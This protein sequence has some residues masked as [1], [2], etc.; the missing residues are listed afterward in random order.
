MKALNIKLLRNLC[1]LKGQGLAIAAVIAA[2]VA[3]YVMSFTALESLRLSQQSVYQ[4]QRFA[5]V[6]AN[7]QRAPEQLAERLREVPGVAT[8]ET[9]V[10]APLTMRMDDFDDPITG[11]AVS[12]PDGTQPQLNQLFLRAGQLPE[13]G[14]ADQILVSEAFAEAQELALGETL[15]IVIGGRF[16]RLQ[17]SGVALSPEYIY[18]IRPG[19]LFPDFSRYA[20]VWMNRSALAAAFGMEGAFNNVVASLSPGFSA[21]RVIEGLDREL[22]RWGGVGAYD[23][24]DQISHRYLEQELMGIES[25]ALFMPFIFIGVAA[26]L[27]NVVAARLIRTQREQIA[28]LKAFGYHST[29]VGAHYLLLVLTVVAIGSVV[30]VAL[31]TWLASGLAGIYQEYFRFP[32]LEFRL[33]PAVALSA[34]LIAGGATVIGT[35]SAVYRAF[36]LPPA[37][38]MRPEPPARFRRTLI[39]RLGIRWLSQPAR[40]ILRNLERQRL[41]SLLSMVGIGFAVAIMMLTGFQRGAINHMMDVQFS[42]AQRQDMTITFAEPTGQRALNELRALPGVLLVEGFRSAPVILRYGHREHQTALQG[43]PDDR[44][45]THVLNDQLQPVELPESGLL[46]T[47]HLA[48]M[49]RVQP[50]DILQVSVQEGR[51]PELNIPVAG[52]VTEFLGVGAYL[53]QNNLTTL[54]REGNTISGAHLMID[55]AHVS[56]LNRRLENMP[57]VAGISLRSNTINAFNEMMDETIIVFTLFSAV[58]AGAIAFAVVYNNARIALAE[59]GRELASLRVLGFTRGE[60][61]YILL[62]ELLL[63]TLLAMPLGFAMGAFLS[64]GLADAM[65]TDMFR[66][67]LVLTPQTYA[68][69]AIVVLVATLI[70]ALIVARRLLRLDIV[71][72]LKA[73]E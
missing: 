17:V 7:L 59:R 68:L 49:L 65:A 12:I 32:W 38:A 57:R 56:E 15:E 42:L 52:L 29:A 40:M 26:F 31:G 50:G 18:Q 73:A 20:I 3:M 48:D 53:R 41:K 43:F 66:I 62:G 69:A 44:T 54:L 67:P 39:E 1:T 34:I 21:E 35:L 16:Q 70:S 6:F 10:Q 64:W 22:D 36:R 51:R 33:R 27:L 24:E 11:V 63:L 30:G 14:R 19:E 9:R 23:R 8:L 72:A 13:P 2:G 4:T 58:M 47:D 71:T 61:A 37:E 45:L 60:V 28:V 46:L 55:P 25:M 5:Q